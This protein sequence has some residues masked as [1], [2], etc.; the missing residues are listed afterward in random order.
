MVLQVINRIRE[1]VKSLNPDVVFECDQ[2]NMVNLKVDSM[3]RYKTNSDGEVILDGEGRPVSTDFVYIE[4][5]TSGTLDVPFVGPRTQSVR[6]DIYFCRFESMQNTG[7]RGDTVVS[8]QSPALTRLELREDIEER[9]VRPFISY[10][11]QTSWGKQQRD[12]LR[13]V[14]VSYPAPRF[15]ANEVSVQL[16]LTFTDTWCAAP[17]VSAFGGGCCNG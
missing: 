9:M 8:E 6:V 3:Q 7:Y 13:S 12:L 15:D 2:S 17:A 14:Q 11:A 4:E 16:S 1:A 10:I 5:P